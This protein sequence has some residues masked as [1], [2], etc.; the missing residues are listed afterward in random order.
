MRSVTVRQWAG[1]AVSLA[2]GALG[3]ILPPA[4]FAQAPPQPLKADD[5][6][7]LSAFGERANY[8]PDGRRIVFIGKSYGDAY[9][10][11]LATRRIRNLTKDF[12]HQGMMRIQFLPDGNYLVT[13]PVRY[14]GPNSRARLQMWVLDKDLRKGLQ[15]LGEKPFEGIAVSKARNLIAWTALDPEPTFKPGE[16]W[17]KIYAK[18]TKT[19]RYIAE[20]QYRNGVPTITGKKEIMAEQPPECTATEPQDFRDHDRELLFTCLDVTASGGPLVSVMGYRFDTGKYVTYRRKLGEYNEVEGV[21]PDGGWAAVECGAQS[22]PGLI[23]I[24]RLELRPDGPISRLIIG[25]APGGTSLVS[26]PVVSPDGEWIAF[27]KADSAVGEPGEGMGV[28]MVRIP[29]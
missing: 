25:T 6:V 1:M 16:S 8:S 22:H 17:M 12:P 23:D 4:G 20:I 24:C 19:R 15:P 3:L 9:E 29:R 13:A 2:V 28:Y 14:I 5:A 21:S 26:N 18:G 27:E 10:V 11:D 7:M